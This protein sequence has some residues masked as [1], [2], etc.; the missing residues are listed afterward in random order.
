LFFVAMTRARK[1]LH[2]C[3]AHSRAT[4]G[5]H[6]RTM[7]SRFLREIDPQVVQGLNLSPVDRPARNFQFVINPRRAEPV[8]AEDPSRP[9]CPYRSGQRI[10]HQ[11][12]GHGVIEEIHL[13][14]GHH[15]GSIRFHTAGM[16]KIALDIAPLQAVGTE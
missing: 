15:M 13:S 10:Y 1:R 12:F 3:Y 8:L 7:P 11:K 16:R 14:G 9:K 5:S 2:L 6:R 4:R